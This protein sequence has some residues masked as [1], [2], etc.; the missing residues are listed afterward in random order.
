MGRSKDTRLELTFR[1]AVFLRKI[2]IL[3]IYRMGATAEHGGDITRQWGRN[4]IRARKQGCN[5]WNGK[6]RIL[7][8]MGDFRRPIRVKPCSLC[9]EQA[10]RGWVHR[11]ILEDE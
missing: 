5:R 9:T 8:L 2:K 6:P 11:F 3:A 1:Q 7:R 10:Y 4:G